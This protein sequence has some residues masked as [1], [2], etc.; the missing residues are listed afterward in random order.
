MTYD[1]R[2]EP[3]YIPFRLF[4]AQIDFI[5][6]LSERYHN[7]ESFIAEKCRDVGFTWLCCAFLIHLWLFN[8]GFKGTVGSRK[9]DLVDRLG[10][11]DCIFEKMRF[12]IEN[13]PPFLHPL[14]YQSQHMKLINHDMSS[15]ITGEAGDNMGRGGRSS[16]YLVDEAAFIERAEKV[17]AAIS[18]N[19]DVKGWLS[20]PNGM[21]NSF[22]IKRHKGVLP[23]FTFHWYDDPRKT[24]KWY[25]EQQEELDPVVFAQEVN[26]DYA[27]SQPGICIPR[28]WV[29][30]A[31]DLDLPLKGDIIAGLDIAD[32][33]SNENVL[34]VRQ[35]NRIVNIYSWK[36]ENLV[37]TAHKAM[38]HCIELGALRIQYDAVGVGAGVGAMFVE[39]YLGQIIKIGLK[40]GGEPTQRY[41]KGERKTSK[42]KFKNLRAEMWWLMREKFR[43]TYDHVNGIR[44]VDDT[45]ELIS[46]PRNNQLIFQ[47]SLPLYSFKDNG[48]I[49]IESKQDM[50]KRG[51]L[52]PDYADSA[53]YCNFPADVNNFKV[54]QY[55][56]SR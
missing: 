38:S 39:Y 45:D 41:W 3:A 54:S 2:V 27:A 1:P 31:V 35:G 14:K 8:N 17:D 20:T 46:I 25:K 26:I 7:R 55:N 47:L 30:A 24:K 34:T 6:W 51:V 53:V 22:A 52:S 43:K 12:I 44:V 11:P 5:Q 16:L 4:D 49:L 36:G 21:G 13:L 23:V 40:S 9:E 50:R 18:A 10:D 28:D 29:M 37:Q 56:Y 19:S 15:I 48:L 32:E 33:G 42:D